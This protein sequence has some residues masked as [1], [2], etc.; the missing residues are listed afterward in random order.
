MASNIDFLQK[1]EA[2]VAGRLENPPE[3]SYTARLAEDSADR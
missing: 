3:G 1:L 2:V